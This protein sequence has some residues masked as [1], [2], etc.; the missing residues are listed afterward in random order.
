[1]CDIQNANCIF[2]INVKVHDISDKTHEHDYRVTFK[3]HDQHSTIHDMFDKTQ[4]NTFL[5]L[6]TQET[7]ILYVS[8]M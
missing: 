3:T 7:Y 8:S 5:H 1:M 6:C 2:F 4:V